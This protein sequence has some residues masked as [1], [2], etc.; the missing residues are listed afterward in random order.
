VNKLKNDKQN[1]K[2]SSKSKLQTIYKTINDDPFPRFIRQTFFDAIDESTGNIIDG[3]S[4]LYA[5]TEWGILNKDSGLYEKKG[6]R[7]GENPDQPA[8][9]YRLINGNL[10][11]GD[12]EIISP[13]NYLVSFPELV[14]SGKH[15]GKI[16]LTDVDSALNILKYLG[17]RPSCVIVKHNNPCGVSR[18]D[19]LV[20][21]Y[22]TANLADRVAAFGGAVVF[23]Q[24]IDKITAESICDNYAEVIAAPE[25]E[26]G[27]LDLFEKKKNLRIIKIKNINR[28]QDFVN[29]NYLE[30]KS[31]S[32]GG[33][34]LQLNQKLNNSFENLVPAH[35]T[36]RKQKYKSASNF[37]TDLKPDVEFGL[38]V[39]YGVTSNSIIFVK[40]ET[41]V[42]IGTGEQDRVGVAKIAVA[43][44]YDK[45]KDRAAWLKY[46]IPYADITT[47]QAELINSEVSKN[48]A[49]L[50]CSI[51]ISD[52]FFPFPDGVEVGLAQGIAGVVQPGGSINDYQV[53]EAC[54]KVHVPML[55]TGQ[56][57]F[58]H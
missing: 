18:K 6:L 33:M 48:C 32:D 56:R 11:I 34:V 53:I 25:F 24:S 46:K 31:L 51:M 17:A 22:Q 5:K 38:A 13:D 45:A 47:S 55:F 29:S 2:N 7:Y 41:T 27:V 23:N 54:N 21:A 20:K 26:D 52:G 50:D 10:L 9:L 14:Q 39:E 36:Y 49:G 43:K 3:Q 15:P 57:L 42:A 30:F 28:L 37:S 4:L 1:L 58:K 16:N 35:H 12:I 19:S 8:A 44:A 40:D